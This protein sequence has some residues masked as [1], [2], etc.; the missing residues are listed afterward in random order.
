MLVCVECCVLTVARHSVAQFRHMLEELMN[1]LKE[2][3][4]S[5]CGGFSIR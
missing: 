5:S 2:G 4:A 1:G 3:F